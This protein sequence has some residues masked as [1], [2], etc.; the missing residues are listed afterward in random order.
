MSHTIL[1]VDDDLNIL[2]GLTRALR[3]ESY[4]VLTAVSATDALLLLKKRSV[5]LIIADEEMPG[6][7]GMEMMQ[8]VRDTFGGVVRFILTGRATLK[9]ALKAINDNTIHRL[10][11]KPCNMEEL[12]CSIRKALAK[13]DLL[14][15]ASQI[16]N[17]SIL[18]KKLEMENP[19]ISRVTRNRRGAILLEEDSADLEEFMD[20]LE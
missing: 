3:K 7:T 9:L 20:K 4:N 5:D 8:R 16:Q 1:L 15:F 19:G 11:T 18:L 12:K 17:Q 14:E 10:F 13:K 6:M 2:A